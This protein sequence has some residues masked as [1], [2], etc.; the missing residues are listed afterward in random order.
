MWRTKNPSQI[1]EK[2]LRTIVLNKKCFT[3]NL[4]DFYKEAL[5]D[6][7][8]DEVR[9][10]SW[11]QKRVL[12][13]FRRFFFLLHRDAQRVAPAVADRDFISPCRCAAHGMCLVRC[14]EKEGICAV[15]LNA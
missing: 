7:Q 3:T 14:E 12:N 8:K 15:H 10:C 2:V 6:I 4:I 11:H 9:F 1:S 13:M 5:L